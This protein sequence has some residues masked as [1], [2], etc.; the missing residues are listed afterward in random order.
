MDDTIGT[1]AVRFL[2]K[3]SIRE[4]IERNR[5]T[6]WPDLQ[7]R[8]KA[9]VYAFLVNYDHRE[10]AI[11]AGLSANSGIKM[12]RHPLIEAFVA[13][14]QEKLATNSF[15]TKEYIT[16]HLVNLIPMLTGQVEVPFTLPNGEQCSGKQFKPA[17]LR[18]VLQD[19][20]KTVEGYDKNQNFGGG[21]SGVTVNID[22]KSLVGEDVGITIEGEIDDKH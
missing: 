4:L 19:L 9:F 10:A 12:L 18:G 14:Q 6:N 7:P 1:Q 15:I 21:N 16:T 13:F 2:D 3:D 20:A 17:E 5:K 11:T 22:L 8:Q